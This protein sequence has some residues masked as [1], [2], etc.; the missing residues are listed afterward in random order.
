MK[1]NNQEVS[2]LCFGT[3]ISN[4]YR[5][6]IE[7]TLGKVKLAFNIIMNKN[8]NTSK[9]TWYLPS[10]IKTSMENGCRMFDTSRAYGASEF[11]LGKTLKKYP[12]DSFYIV[13]K[14]C[15][16]AQYEGKV[17]EYFLESLKQLDMDYVDLYLMHWPVKG[18]FIESWKEM[19][20]IYNEG[21]CKAIGVCNF[22]EH[23]LE[24]LK[25][26]A[27]IMPMVNQIE[28]HPLF[29][30]EKLREYC[31]NNNIKVMAYTATGRMDD[32]LKKTVLVPISKKYNKSI[33]QI[34][35][36]WHQQIGNIPIFNTTNKKHIL[37]NI[38]IND[39]ELTEDEIESISKINI[40]SRLRYDPDNCDF[41]QL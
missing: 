36:K 22:N 12:R 6:G 30:Q 32:R 26:H 27:S 8:K 3:G 21:L 17:R 5:W 40:N 1:I 19:E 18:H 7:R 15:N 28:C 13:T 23:H 41:S 39:F 34:I 9:N 10:I 25:K 2:N 11:I 31:K 16:K 38:S 29:T 14:L 24:E 4:L 20:K 33:T 35:L 37:E